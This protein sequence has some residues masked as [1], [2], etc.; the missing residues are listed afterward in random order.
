MTPRA[1]L[2]TGATGKQ[3]G[4]VIDA[5]LKTNAPFEILALTRDARSKSSQKLLQKSPNIKLVTGNLDAI[6]D[7]FIKAKEVTNAQIWGVFSVQALT[8]EENQGKSLVDAS[9]KHGVRHFVY[10]SVDRGGANSD[11][12]P[13]YIPHFITKYNIEKHLFAKA[14][15]SN[16]S[17]TVLR[18]VG[19]MDNL[20]PG[21]LGKVSNTSWEMKL[22]K[23]QKLQV[24]AASDIG[25][26]AADS[27]LK[28][29]SDQYRNKSISL[30]G[31]ELTFD[32]FKNIF[33]QTTHE[34]LPTTYWFLTTIVHWLV[35]EPRLGQMYNWFRDVGFGADIQSLKKVHPD[36]KDTKAW[37]ETDSA[38]KS[39]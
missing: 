2:I 12:D 1:V 4:S 5:F 31:D 16:M 25:F 32:E 24:I 13:T 34:T 20:V 9:L 27:F 17:W 8:N 35:K 29:E 15:G 14:K 18:P 30:A 38:W 28:P 33:G 19:F 6:E 23:T 39:R 22:K 11:N 37:L 7:I 26:F 10:S 3:G 36:L 21:F